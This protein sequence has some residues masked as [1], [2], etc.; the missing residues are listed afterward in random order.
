MRNPQQEWVIVI[1]GKLLPIDNCLP[2]LIGLK[3]KQPNCR[4]TIITPTPG[5]EQ[6]LEKELFLHEMVLKYGIEILAPNAFETIFQ[7]FRRRVFLVTFLL[8][9]SFFRK[10]FFFDIHL[11]G[12]FGKIVSLLNKWIHKGKSFGLLLSNLEATAAAYFNEISIKELKREPPLFIPERYDGLLLSFGADKFRNNEELKKYN[13]IEVGYT[14]GQPQWLSEIENSKIEQDELTSFKN[15]F[16]FWPLSIIKRDERGARIFDLSFSISTSLRILQEVR[17]EVGIV[18][19]YHPTTERDHFLKLLEESRFQNYHI[20]DAH[21]LILIRKSEF[22]FSN[23]GTT[24]YSDAWFHR[25]P[26]VQYSP[27]PHIIGKHDSDGQLVAPSYAPIVNNFFKTEDQFKLFL[28]QWQGSQTLVPNMQTEQDVSDR[29]KVIDINK[30]IK[31]IE[32]C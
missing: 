24:I 13:K 8:R 6:M 15:G 9:I 21:P 14:R 19:R 1:K 29:L 7:K 20:S 25:I 3:Q 18:F 32:N 11:L 23:I 16:I 17:P 10:V 30:I 31:E 2:L 5:Y 4:V 28:Q 12:S 26:V 27:D 22:V